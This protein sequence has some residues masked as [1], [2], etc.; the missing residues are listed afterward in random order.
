MPMSTAAFK[1]NIHRRSPGL[2][3]CLLFAALAAFA[4]PS[5]AQSWPQRPVRVVITF[6]PGGVT[7][8]L[9]RTVA[10]KLTT[11]LKQPFV[12]EPHGGAG[13]NIGGELVAKARP[14]GHT[15]GIATDT[16]WTINP[17]IYR[18]MSFE[19]AR[20]LL[21]VMVMASFAQVLTCNP[22]LGAKTLDA[23]IQLGKRQPLSYASGGAG[24]PG[25][26]AMELLLS[27]AGVSMTH[28]PYRGAA[29]ASADIIGNQVNC[30][31]LPG[32]TVMPHVNSGRLVALAVSSE[33]R[34][35]LAPDVP[36]V[37]ESG[38]PGFNATF[39]LVLFAPAG[40][41]QAIL[42]TLTRETATAL[43]DPAVMARLRAVDLAPIGANAAHTRKA[44]ADDAEMWT[45]VVRKIDLKLD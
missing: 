43:A 13:G 33:Q 4:A 32:P 3:G 39:K 22:A 20:D 7:D 1:H 35:P 5:S 21:P 23:L 11:A 27:R 10:E 42:D 29:P 41:P 17:L 19:P 2:I 8:V 36:T 12:V 18:K 30:G 16:L 40:T 26:L 34:S 38:F 14:D 9:A 44:L 28:V 15:F 31:F 6:P 25:H 24:V 37:A 45:P